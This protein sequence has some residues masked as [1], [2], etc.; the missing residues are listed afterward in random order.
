[1]I[2]DPHC[3]AHCIAAPEQLRAQHHNGVFRSI[4][5]GEHWERIEGIE[6]STFGF[7]VAAHPADGSTA[8][9]VPAESDEVRIPIDGRVVVTRTRNGGRS[10]E[11]LE[12]GSPQQ[13]AYDLVFRHA[14][15]VDES[16]NHLCFG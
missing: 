6:P 15:D 4:N 3:V 12:M 11:R 1:M 16:G 5:A 2:Q 9:L 14:L 7:A 10:W 13:D 8:W